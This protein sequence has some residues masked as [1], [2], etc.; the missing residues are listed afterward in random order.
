MEDNRKK[1]DAKCPICEHEF[2][3]CKSILHEMGM[4]SAGHGSCPECSTS[5]NLTFDP[6][7]DKMIITDWNTWMN[8]REN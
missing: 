4:L 6:K 5:I 7:E 2:K 1:Y 8:K 3:A